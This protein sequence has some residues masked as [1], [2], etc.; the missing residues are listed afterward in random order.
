[1]ISEEL[2]VE[3]IVHSYEEDLKGVPWVGGP[4]VLLRRGLGQWRFFLHFFA[5]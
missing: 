4:F 1:M 2:G 5:A 3:E